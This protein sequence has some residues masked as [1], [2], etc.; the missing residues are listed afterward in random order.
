M[1]GRSVGQKFDD[2]IKCFTKI[3]IMLQVL[4]LNYCLNINI[5]N[6][7]SFE[8]ATHFFNENYFLACCSGILLRSQYFALCAGKFFMNTIKKSVK[9]A[10]KSIADCCIRSNEK[11]ITYLI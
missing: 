8:N 5:L 11:L 4:T 6:I 10:Y 2:V 9:F 7:L 1:I 3:E